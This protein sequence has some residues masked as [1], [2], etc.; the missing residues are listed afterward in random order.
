ML[1][2]TPGRE[3]EGA[4]AYERAEGY[5]KG[6]NAGTHRDNFTDRV[7]EGMKHIVHGTGPTVYV[8][9]TPSTSS[10]AA[11]PTP[12][13]STAGPSVKPVTDA[14]VFAARQRIVNGSRD[15]R[16][17]A[18]IERYGREQTAHVGARGQALQ[19]TGDAA[20][21]VQERTLGR[22]IHVTK[23]MAAAGQMPH[24]TVYGPSHLDAAHQKLADAMNAEAAARMKA[25][26][27]IVKGITDGTMVV[28][29]LH[30]H[31]LVSSHVLNSIHNANR[32]Q[33]IERHGD[34][35]HIH[36]TDAK[37]GL[38]H[39]MKVSARRE[40]QDRVRFGQG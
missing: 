18:I 15:P 8:N 10:A 5:A 12:A 4:S 27:S 32:S 25:V 23:P 6:V 24:P 17:H 9:G 29:K 1:L 21:P 22:Y 28:P 38:D 13:A 14:E 34:S 36:G 30:P 26:Q 3:A 37:S 7:A 2:N 35:F 33:H 20:H 31:Q 39:A 40:G 19:P 16:D 11:A